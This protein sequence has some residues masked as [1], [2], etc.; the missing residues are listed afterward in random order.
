MSDSKQM[1]QQNEV[2]RTKWIWVGIIGLVVVMTGLLYISSDR[3]PSVSSVRAQHIL[4]SFDRNDPNDRAAALDLIQDIRQ[5]I[6]NGESFRRLARRY[7]EDPFSAS[8]GG[9]LGFHQKGSFDDAFEDYVWSAP[10]N[11][12]SDVV[13]SSH[14]FHLI[15]VLDRFLTDVD[16]YEMELE[17]RVREQQAE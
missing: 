15:I 2:D 4:I 14:G 13:Q 11:V 17:E 7:S 16:S 3:R 6:N 1:M 9:D 5:R 12:L 10:V 8:R